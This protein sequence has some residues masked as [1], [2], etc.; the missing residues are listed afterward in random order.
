MQSAPILEQEF[1]PLRAKLLEIAAALDR[2]DRSDEVVQREP[3]LQKIRT[4]IELLLTAEGD[5]AEQLQL[6][7]SRAYEGDWQSKFGLAKS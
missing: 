5:R 1:L 7:F 6:V 2:L 4:A 3:R